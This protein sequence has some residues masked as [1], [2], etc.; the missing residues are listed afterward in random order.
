[1]A[2]MISGATFSGRSIA[3][4]NFLLEMA[5]ER[6]R[7]SFI[8]FMNTFAFPLAFFP[9]LGGIFADAF[10]FKALFLISFLSGLAM[11]YCVLHLEEV[12]S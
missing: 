5:P 3:Q 8:A 10:G 4:V 7:P 6:R 12:R 11:L 9:L 1:M 2:L